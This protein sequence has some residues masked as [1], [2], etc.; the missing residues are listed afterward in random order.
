MTST[1]NWLEFLEILD[2]AKVYVSEGKYFIEFVFKGDFNYCR[3]ISFE[4]AVLK[5]LEV[6]KEKK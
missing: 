4:D 3:S 5:C 6:I 2:Y 1:D